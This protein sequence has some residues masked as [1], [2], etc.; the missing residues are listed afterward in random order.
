M[1]TRSLLLFL[2]LFP[3]FSCFSQIN[4]DSLS[5]VL[6]KMPSDTASISKII[7]QGKK[8]M[9]EDIEAANGVFKIAEKK[10]INSSNDIQRAIIYLNLANS[11]LRLSDAKNASNYYLKAKALSERLKNNELL[12]EIHLGLGGMYWQNKDNKNALLNFNKALALCKKDDYKLKTSI[13]GNIG[14][15]YYTLSDVPDKSASNGIRK[16][17]DLVRK[18]IVYN[19]R[20][21]TI[22]QEKNLARKVITQGSNLCLEYIDLGK[23]D[24]ASF[25]LKIVEEGISK[26]PD[27]QLLT[28]FYSNKARL[29]RAQKQY[30]EA[31]LAYKKSIEN[32]KILGEVRFEYEG[33]L[34]L[35]ETF[36]EKNDLKSAI[37]YYN[38]YI[39][40]KDSALSQENF[41][42]AADLQNKYESQKKESEILKLNNDNLKKSNL[43]KILI[44]SFLALLALSFLG[45]RNFKN[46]QKIALQ[47][48][49]IQTQK[50][51][52][53]EKDK[54]LLA[55]DAL[56]RGQEE[57]RNRIAK[58]LHDGLGGML[59]GVKMSFVNMKENL[60]MDA[61]NVKNFE[62]SISQLDNTIAE[63]R[64]VAHNLMPEA[65][66]KFGLKDAIKDFCNSMESSSHVK[67]IY[68]FF[69]DD[70]K[71]GNTAEVYIYRII[72]E[73]VSNAI[74]H[75]EPSQIVVQMTVAEKNILL[76]VEDNGMGINTEKQNAS[77]GI[78]LESVKQ[79]VDYLNGTLEFDSKEPTGTAVNIELNA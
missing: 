24:S 43:N 62:K 57:E 38:L 20:A 40:T 51:A 71:I 52:E 77:K 49:E 6:N 54:L 30:S 66:A 17:K 31:I 42:E 21:F 79:R 45:Y 11:Y 74:K 46:R 41:A 48:E 5:V 69:G 1:N 58:D 60:I 75:A 25:F 73:L 61:E 70:R 19:K 7:S 2:F 76:T 78:G 36:E 56:L 4:K 28:S 63:L 12:G 29:L 35:A 23:L 68:Q 18:A 65:L 53:L 47:T 34:A 32:G 14:M 64:K 8:L 39:N 3:F 22:A 72:Q 67:I 59:S 9:A 55:V 44:V 50:I 13:L 16:D 15:I 27:P 10:A 37:K 26:N 33:Y